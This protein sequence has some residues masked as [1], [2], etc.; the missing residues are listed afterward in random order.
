MI[1]YPDDNF[2]IFV[3]SQKDRWLG[4]PDER[5]RCFICGHIARY[6]GRRLLS[7]HGDIS[8]GVGLIT[9]NYE[10][11]PDQ[12]DRYPVEIYDDIRAGKF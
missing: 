3:D 5:R 6:R 7:T 1:K 2:K 12:K 8:I 4:M 10:N 9:I 11:Y